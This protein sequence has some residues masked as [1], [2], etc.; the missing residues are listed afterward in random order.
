MYGPPG[1]GKT[2]A[3][4]DLALHVSAGRDW[5]GHRVDQGAAIYIAAEA[6]LGISNRVAAWRQH[7]GIVDAP[8]AAL[9]V[10]VDLCHPVGDLD[11][12]LEAIRASRLAPGLITIDT[13]SRALGGGNENAPDDMGAFVR[14]LDILRSE[15]RSHVLGVHHS[16]KD[17]SRGSRG[18]SSLHCAVDTEIEI[19]REEATGILTGTV[20][21]QRDGPTGGQI[22]FR[23][24]QVELGRDQDGEPVASCVLEPAEPTTGPEKREAR[25]SPRNQIALDILRKAIAEAGEIGPTS[26]HIPANTGASRWTFGGAFT[27]WAPPR[28]ARAETPGGK[29]SSAP[30]ITCK[31]IIS[32]GFGVILFGGSVE[33]TLDTPIGVCPVQSSGHRWTCPRMSSVH[34]KCPVGG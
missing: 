3:A 9:T 19:A 1:S 15:L 4:L 23:L 24:R 10:P 20:S 30:A 7:T 2:F 31:P 22:T 26:N 29:R 17:A 6:G 34:R 12:L 25:L 16:G 21:K 5:L 11:R 33:W 14:S 28:T 32:L 8:F 27:F 13:V 18:H